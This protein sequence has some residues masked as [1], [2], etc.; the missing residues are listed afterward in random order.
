MYKAIIFD[1]FGVIH[2]DQYKEWLTKHG[3]KK[4]GEFSS[5]SKKADKGQ[6][7]TDEFFQAISS[8]NNSSLEEVKKEFETNT[9][10]DKNMVNLILEFKKQGYTI[11]LLSNASSNYLHGINGFSKI[12]KIFD[13]VII[14]GNEGMAKPDPNF[15]MH[16]LDLLGVEPEEAIFIDDSP[17]NVQS[18]NSLG[19]DSFL[20]TNIEDLQKWLSHKIDKR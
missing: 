20:Y 17:T 13:H 18:A 2:N 14:S 4:D 10:I 16:A 7:S 3:L 5:L 19:I 6:I 12:E 11:A 8:L 1:F 9:K 15:F